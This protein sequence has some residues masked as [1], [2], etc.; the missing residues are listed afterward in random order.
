MFSTYTATMVVALAAALGVL[1]G[2]ACAQNPAASRDPRPN[3]IVIM[4]DDM[5]YS[6]IGA[7]GSEIRTPNLDR[8]GADGLRF[9][10]FYTNPVCSPTRASLLTG[11][12]SHE[13]GIGGNAGANPGPHGPYQGFLSEQSVTLAEALREA[14]YRTYM[15][16]K[17]HLGQNRESWPRRRGFDR[18]FGLLSGT[19]SYF[20]LLQEPGR[21]RVMALED[22]SWT[23]PREGYYATDAYTEYAVDRIHEHRAEHSAQ[24]FFLYLAYTAPHFPLHALP[25]DIAR[26]ERRYDIGWDSLRLE[27]Y[28]RMREL[29]I[30]DDRHALAPRPAE[31]PA[32]NDV[33]DKQDW[34]RRMA[35][36]AA[37]VDRMDQGIG[38]V[39]R[40][41]QETGM[42]DNTLVLFFSDNGASAEDVSGR[43]MNDPT[44]PIGTRGSYVSYNEPWANAS[45]T[46]YRLYKSW[47]HEGGIITPLI[48]YWPRGIREAGHLSREV[49][50]VI[51][52]MPTAL[53][54]A[55][56][57][58]P[59]VRNGRATLPLQ[60]RS[61]A[62][63]LRG[64]ALPA[65]EAPLFWALGG[66]W[67]VRQGDWKLTY[68]ARRSERLEL[69][70]LAADPVEL[71]DLSA[72]YPERVRELQAL[73][74]TWAE[75][76]GARERLAAAPR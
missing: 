71:H 6:D 76:V 43:G 34:A 56:A 25:E 22:S 66:N 65:R 72:R 53:E 2:G 4:A 13:A 59:Q 64:E 63:V 60:G 39:L 38:R 61:L 32:W 75:R 40:A 47:T 45:M 58:Y 48:A 18:F 10:N 28:A 31:V 16:G 30:L 24:P 29:G 5:G 36:Y 69:F 27:R 14:G 11:L 57:A 17:W 23:P 21:V 54:L 51:D 37:M 35:V 73:W 55:G 15:S 12:Y 70:N 19:T 44:V 74:Q 9:T 26:Y 20:E 52:L 41:L 68:D 67:A 62:G 3:I 1:T 46:P 7:F 33:P 50:H 42:S 8:L 49:G